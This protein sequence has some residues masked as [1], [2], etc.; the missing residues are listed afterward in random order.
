MKWSAIIEG[1]KDFR[2]SKRILLM[3]NHRQWN[4]PSVGVVW[5]P[6]LGPKLNWFT[7][8]HRVS[9]PK[10]FLQILLILEFTHAN[11][12][13]DHRNLDSA[14]K[15]AFDRVCIASVNITSLN[16]SSLLLTLID[17]Q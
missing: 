3:S 9:S 10:H 1:E 17:R 6:D 12:Y 11:S 5:K 16:D 4:S 13:C 8:K 2:Y 15:S 7:V 14:C